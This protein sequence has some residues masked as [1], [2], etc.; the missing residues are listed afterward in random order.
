L[1]RDES[2]FYLNYEHVLLA[3][4]APQGLGAVAFYRAA[5]SAKAIGLSRIELDAAGGQG[6]KM[7]IEGGWWRSYNGYYSW[8][9]F[10]FDAEITSETRERLKGTPFDPACTTLLQLMEWD[11]DWWKANGAGGPMVFDL[12]AGRRS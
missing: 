4:D 8:P 10:G 9:R 1:K 6:Y 5:R 3:E 12:A 7:G 2:G 11:A